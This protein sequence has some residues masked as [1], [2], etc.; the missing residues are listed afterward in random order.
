MQRILMECV[1]R[2]ALIAAGTGLVL[3]IVRVRAAA[4]RHAVWAGVVA[5][6]LLLPV[7]SVWGPKA[8]LRV[9][10]PAS[11]APAISAQATPEAVAFGPGAP[12]A[13]LPNVPRHPKISLLLLVYL[14]GASILLARL[15][16]GT[17]RAN[18]LRGGTAAPITVGWLHPRIILPDEWREWTPAR[19]AAVMAHE[20]EHARRRDPLVQ[21]IAL[22][23]RAVFWFHPLAWWLERRISTLAEEACDDAVL[24]A[25][26][27]PRGYAECL[28]A[29]ARSVAQHGAVVNVCGTAMPG[30]SLGRRICRI[31]E[32]RAVPRISRTRLACAVAACVLCSLLFGAATLED[33]QGQ[34]AAAVTFE[35]VSVKPN[36]LGDSNPTGRGGS[37]HL[38]GAQLSMNNV[39]LWKIV[40]NAFGVGEDKDYAISGPGWLKS[41]RYD[42]AAK[43]P[44]EVLKD[45]ANLRQN[46]PIML[47][48]MLAQRFQMKT[49]R[50]T[51]VMPAYALVVGKGEPKLKPS[52]PGR[53]P[54]RIGNGRIEAE[55]QVM[56]HFADILS[57]FVDRPIID[58]TG[59]SGAYDFKLE[60]AQQAPVDLTDPERR[61]T[62]ASMGPSLFTA[63]QEQLGLRLEPQRLPVEVL[64]IDRAERVPTEN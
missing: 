37:I 25:G 35:V 58:K 52:E 32:G 33:Q 56:P 43:I 60:W 34:P 2:A 12:S 46:L 62:D 6:M 51:K 10:R 27:D 59:L 16:I 21:W 20:R 45:Q 31:V 40:G 30:G 44:A 39:S 38:D 29:M 26:H 17:V 61:T 7:W 50:E 42:I 9:L 64:V 3:A 49:H 18:R 41:E 22:L 4:A 55:K 13:P 23:N 14:A 11:A 47:Q 57:Q 36:K 54:M 48:T 8:P 5:A 63:I 28:L 24:A 15:A 19:L 1:V 53:G